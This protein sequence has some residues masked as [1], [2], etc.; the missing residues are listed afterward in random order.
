MGQKKKRTWT[1]EERVAIMIDGLKGKKSVQELSEKYGISP[2]QFYK[3]RDK[4]LEAGKK[5]LLKAPP[6]ETAGSSKRRFER[7][8]ARLPARIESADSEQEK[9]IANLLTGNISAGGAYF[10]TE[11]PMPISTKVKLDIIL[12]MEKLGYRQGTN[13]VLV[14]VNGSVLRSNSTGMAIIFDEDYRIYRLRK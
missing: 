12:P 5:A 8:S 1:D 13:H 7:V 3:W 2:A 14:K 6:A 10:H 9:K 11:Q 4:L